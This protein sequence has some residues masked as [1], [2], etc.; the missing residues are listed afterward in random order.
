M[1]MAVFLYLVRGAKRKKGAAT[2]P[3]N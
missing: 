1:F 3:Q 2:S